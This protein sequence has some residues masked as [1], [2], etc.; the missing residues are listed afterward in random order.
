MSLRNGPCDP[1]PE[2][3]PLGCEGPVVGGRE[4]EREHRRDNDCCELIIG[5]I[6]G[7]VLGN[8]NHGRRHDRE[9]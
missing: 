4:H 6:I 5:I 7:L 9:C 3:G 8:C 1:G 2:R